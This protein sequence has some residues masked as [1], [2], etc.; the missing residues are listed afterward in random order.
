M[1][2]KAD[3]IM[4]TIVFIIFVVVAVV[5]SVISVV[6]YN[7]GKEERAKYYMSAGNI[8]KEDFLNYALTNP[9]DSDEAMEM[10]TSRKTMIFIKTL[11]CKPKSQFV[12][13]PKRQIV[14][15]RD[16]NNSNIYINEV[17]VSKKHCCI[18]AEG[19]DVFLADTGSA[20][21]TVVRRGL[22]KKYYIGNM[23]RIQ[24]KTGDRI[25]IGSTKFKVV[26]FYYDM[27]LM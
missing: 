23:C 6:L 7:R 22:F 16:K 5:V 3:I 13:D 24:L 2:R 1:E 8:L 26:L 14:I 25:K 19:F 18:Y 21:G 12:F 4:E 11:N 27:A 20:N 9:L 10:P 15:G 17:L